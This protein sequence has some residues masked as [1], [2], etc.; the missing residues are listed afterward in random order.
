LRIT[1]KVV[2]KK[3]FSTTVL[4]R[5]QVPDLHKHE[6]KYASGLP[7][8][9]KHKIDN[10]SSFVAHLVQNLLPK[11][12]FGQQPYWGVLIYPNIYVSIPMGFPYP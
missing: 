8:I 4:K 7:V 9:N 3:G 1:F 10:T 11:P 2:I 6:Y 5:I 12:F